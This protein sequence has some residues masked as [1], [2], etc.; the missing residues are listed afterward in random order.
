NQDL[1]LDHQGAGDGNA[2]GRYPAQ[3]S[4]GQRQ[5]ISIA[6]ALMVE[7]KILI[8]DE[9]VSALDV[10]VQKDV[11]KLLADIRRS[12][13]LTVIFITHDLRVAAE[14]SDHI[15]VM[16]KGEVVEYGTVDDIFGNPRH[17]YTRQLL[18]AMPGR[19]WEAPD[20]TALAAVDAAR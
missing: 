19:S 7:P 15:L 20:M 13:G 2:L 14:I 16:S 9:A 4:G 3:F 8:A 5:R 10:S 1:R 6:R 18:A 11:L 12:V 17:P